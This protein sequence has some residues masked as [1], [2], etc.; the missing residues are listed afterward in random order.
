MLINAKVYNFILT[1]K[2]MSFP[3]D[4]SLIYI[5]QELT[6][7]PSFSERFVSAIENLEAKPVVAK[8]SIF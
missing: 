2:N 1:E 7:D 5:K 3:P 6:K 8:D 4:A